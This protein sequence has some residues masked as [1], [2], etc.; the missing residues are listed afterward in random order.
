V[1]E[2]KGRTRKWKLKLDAKVWWAHPQTSTWNGPV[3][4][5]KG[6]RNLTFQKGQ[7]GRNLKIQNWYCFSSVKN[8]S[9]S[10]IRSIDSQKSAD[11]K[12]RVKNWRN[13]ESE[14]LESSQ[15]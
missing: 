10:E 5:S 12:I 6:P 14:R 3:Q 7:T 2:G 9:E 11:N 8:D 1:S 4:N 15:A 13:K